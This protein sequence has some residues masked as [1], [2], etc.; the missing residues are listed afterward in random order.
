MAENFEKAMRRLRQ[1]RNTAEA[2]GKKDVVERINKQ[3]QDLQ[4]KF[5]KRFNDRTK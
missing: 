5:N 1:H 3:I 4:K 2:A